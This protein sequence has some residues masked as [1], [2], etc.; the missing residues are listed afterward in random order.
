MASIEWTEER[1][2]V[3]ARNRDATGYTWRSDDR[4]EE[5]FAHQFPTS[6]NWFRSRCHHEIRWTLRWWT[7]GPDVPRCPECLEM[8]EDAIA[9]EA[10]AIL[11]TAAREA[12][13]S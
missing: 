12:V 11:S 3:A 5:P 13:A 10:R 7:A 8:S 9:R 4:H 6:G 1:A 2:L